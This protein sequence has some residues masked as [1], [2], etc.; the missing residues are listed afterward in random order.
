[1][2]RF[3]WLLLLSACLVF[4]FA[5]SAS[6]TM[7]TLMH[8]DA[9]NADDLLSLSIIDEQN[10]FFTSDKLWYDPEDIFDMGTYQWVFHSV[11]GGATLEPRYQW[12]MNFGP[13]FGYSLIT[14][15]DIVMMSPTEGY[16]CGMYSEGGL[17]PSIG[18]MR[19]WVARSADG[20]Y[21]WNIMDGFESGG[22]TNA[23]GFSTMGFVTATKAFAFA[24][25]KIAYKSENGGASWAKIPNLPSNYSSPIPLDPGNELRHFEIASDT[26]L[27]VTAA[28]VYSESYYYYGT[29][30]D[31]DA[32]GDDDDDETKGAGNKEALEGGENGELFYS[33]DGG[34]TWSVIFTYEDGGYYEAG[35][36]KVR[37]FDEDHGWLTVVGIDESDKQVTDILYTTNGGTTWNKGDL[38]TDT[39]TFGAPGDY[40]MY[41]VAMYKADK[42]YAVGYNPTN[43]ISVVLK[44]EDGGET[45]LPDDYSGLGE[46]RGVEMMDNRHGW[47]YG[48]HMTVVSFFNDSNEAPVADAG[49]DRS[50]NP[51]ATLALDATASYDPDDDEITYYWELVDGPTVVLDDPT[52]ATPT[53]TTLNEDARYT[54]QLVVSDWAADSAPDTVEVVAGNPTDDDDDTGDDD[55]TIG[56]DD[57]D[58]DDND[59]KDED[60]SCCG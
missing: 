51:G 41:D 23:Y 1:M 19:P 30:D 38:P 8:Q 29:G 24:T 14:A 53:F 4:L 12:E 60:S 40:V 45:W 27:Y 3:T 44:T 2:R 22:I 52:L 37:F 10:L 20:G 32:V 31:D 48:G 9:E 18:N 25:S 59:D 17:F 58:D 43:Y 21:T 28:Y 54:F 35:F 26:D 7:W 49:P 15:Q 33:G 16:L 36:P 11:D 47:A 6:A 56:D 5:G 39:D 34:N 46:L 42:G 50:V 13:E 55:D 57:D